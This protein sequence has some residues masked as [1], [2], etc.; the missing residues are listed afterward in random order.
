MKKINNIITYM[1]FL[2]IVSVYFLHY[3]VISRMLQWDL[4][5]NIVSFI[6]YLLLIPFIWGLIHSE[7]NELIHLLKK[8]WILILYFIIR[9]SSFYLG[10]ITVNVS[11]NKTI[12]LEFLYLVVIGHFCL[13]NITNI[14]FLFRFYIILNLL[15]NLG[16]VFVY[17][18]IPSGYFSKIPFFI[19]WVSTV[20]N[21]G[22]YPFSALYVNPNIAGVATGIAIILACAVSKKRNILF[23][24]YFIFSLWFVHFQQCRSAQVA[25]LACGIGYLIVRFTNMDGKQFAFFVLMASIVSTLGIGSF[26]IK[27]SSRKKPL[28]DMTKKEQMINNYSTGRYLIWKYDV[29][30]AKK[31][32]LWGSGSLENSK[33]ER[34]E[35]I[36][37]EYPNPQLGMIRFKK[38]STFDFHNGY[39][40]TLFV[41]GIPCFILFIMILFLK[42]KRLSNDK[43][44]LGACFFLV[45]NL[46]ECQFLIASPNYPVTAIMLMLILNPKIKKEEGIERKI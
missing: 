22:I 1:F 38:Y 30:V 3:T 28:E 10:K 14:T 2:I 45:V 4:R 29:N 19:Q 17:I 7:K 43:W 34:K 26:A 16:T 33:N 39:F 25:L 35:I 32:L 36:N 20:G 13:K 41:V 21:Y 42:I 6:G 11:T 31:N 46:F 9:I 18:G 40:G 27:N 37:K 5:L 24:I 12:L 44:A 23:W 8:N 15:L